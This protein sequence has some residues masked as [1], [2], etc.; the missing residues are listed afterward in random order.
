MD[1]RIA[2]L[3]DKEAIRD[4]V[5]RYCR[6][7]DRHD[8]EALRNCY[9][10]DATDDHGSFRG[11]IDEYLVWVEKLLERYSWTMHSVSNSL[12]D[13]GANPD[14]AAGWKGPYLDSKAVP[15]DP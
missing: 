3:L 4:V 5:Y 13:F 2:Q 1:P 8:L 9:H 7:I 14:R 11:T 15:L 6:A 12:I 10:A